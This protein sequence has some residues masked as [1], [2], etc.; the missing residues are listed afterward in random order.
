MAAKV[1]SAG[2]ERLGRNLINCLA[3]YFESIHFSGAADETGRTRDFRFWQ[4][5]DILLTRPN[6]FGKARYKQNSRRSILFCFNSTRHDFSDSRSE[7]P[8]YARSHCHRKGSPKGNA[9]RRFEHLGSAY[10]RAYD[11]EQSKKN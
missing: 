8:P 10:L 7:N 4:E 11:S 3:E 2:V 6:G 1:L 9:N 5:A